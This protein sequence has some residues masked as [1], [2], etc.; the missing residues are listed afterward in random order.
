MLHHPP[1]E[2][3]SQ[4]EGIV[5]YPVVPESPLSGCE[6][7]EETVRVGESPARTDLQHHFRYPKMR[8]SRDNHGRELIHGLLRELVEFFTDLFRCLWLPD[9][10]GHCSPPLA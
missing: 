9:R 4:R 6:G 1:Y 8:E 5:A 10:V 3:S 2:V 7:R